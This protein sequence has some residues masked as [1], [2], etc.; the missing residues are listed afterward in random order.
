MSSQ[1]PATRFAISRRTALG[2]LGAGAALL[3][4]GGCAP[5]GA[6][7]GSLVYGSLT[8]PATLNPLLAPDVASRQ[9]LELVCDG[10]VA[11]DESFRLVPR[12]AERWTTLDEGKVW[13]FHLRP[14]LK[15]GDGTPLAASDVAFTY[16]TLLDP[17]SGA[18][19]ARGDYAVLDRIEALDAQ[20]VRFTLKRPYAPFISRLTVGIVP[21]KA[22]AGGALAGVAFNRQPIGAG[23]YLLKEWASGQRLVFEANPHYWHGKPAVERIVWKVVP[24]TASLTMQLLAG[25]VGA[26]LVADPQDRAKVRAEARLA[27]TETVGGATQISF[28]LD[29]PLFADVRVRRALAL[30]LDVPALIAGVLKGEARP[31]ISDIPPTSWA[32]DPATKPLARDLDAAARLLAA[33]GYARGADGVWARGGEPLAFTLLT[34]AGDRVREATLLTVQQQWKDFGAKVEVGTQERNSFVANRVLKGDFQAALL[35]SAV[36]VD[37]D[38][39]RRFHS[40]SIKAGQNFLGYSSPKLDALLDGANATT[41]REARGRAYAEAQTILLADLPQIPLFHAT[42]LYAFPKSLGG[43]RPNALGPFWSAGEWKP[44]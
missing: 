1:N 12:L 11:A 23:P 28:R 21:E 9:A 15:F 7:S 36:Q 20:T 39:S 44:E 35:E 22:L 42:Q 3:A 41:D 25:E 6:A 8:E 2:A 34:Y 24:D 13:T 32:H 18:T 19:L 26:A 27:T 38:L 17:Q 10:L 31:A 30:A 33:A 5:R 40:A 16:R 14:N 37:P 29:D 43:V 4:L